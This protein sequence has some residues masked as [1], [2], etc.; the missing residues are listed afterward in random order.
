MSKNSA[1]WFKLD[2]AAKIY[3]PTRNAKWNAMFRVSMVLDH[4]ID[5]A[6]LQQA[7]DGLKALDDDDIS[8]ILGSIKRL[9]KK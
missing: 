8:L 9:R 2:N 5:P 4:E 6:L 3:P 1:A 7:F